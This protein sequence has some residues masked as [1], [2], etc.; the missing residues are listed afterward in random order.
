MPLDGYGVVVGSFNRFERGGVHQGRW[1]HGYLYVD[2]PDAVDVGALDVFAAAGVGVQYR[3]VGPVDTGAFA[4]AGALGPGR[5]PLATG[6]EDGPASGA[7]DYVRSPVLGSPAADAWR[8]SDGTNALTALEGAL[9]GADRIWM[10]GSL[11]LTGPR[12]PGVHD[13]HCN[14]G[15]PPTSPDGS[16][17]QADD[18]VWQDGAVVWRRPDGELMAWL[19]KF[20]SQTLDT[21][22]RTGLPHTGRPGTRPPG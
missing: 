19:V 14:Q 21:D 3:L 9:A 4:V 2:L 8:T 15:D 1:F 18:G 20:S 6:P 17:H 11:F 22:D 5:H 7:L 12:G 16:S 10:F 13:V